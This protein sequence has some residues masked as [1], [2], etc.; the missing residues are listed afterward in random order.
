MARAFDPTLLHVAGSFIEAKEKA[1]FTLFKDVTYH[2]TIKVHLVIKL[3]KHDIIIYV[4]VHEASSVDIYT[5]HMVIFN[6]Q[7]NL[8]FVFELCAIFCII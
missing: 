5:T 1:I 8:I 6:F 4:C 3:P 2:C 7:P